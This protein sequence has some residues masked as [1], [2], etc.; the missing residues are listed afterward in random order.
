MH[1]STRGGRGV[2]SAVG[3][4]ASGQ[5]QSQRHRHVR[6]SIAVAACIGFSPRVLET[7]PPRE[8]GRH[9]ALHAPRPRGRRRFFGGSHAKRAATTLRTN[10]GIASR[11]KQIAP[12]ADSLRLIL[13]QL[14]VKSW[15]LLTNSTPSRPR[16]TRLRVKI[17]S[18]DGFAS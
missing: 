9:D 6:N 1:A 13:W 11:H 18:T 5:V 17:F 12:P 16:R 14:F 15:R 4:R 7:M 2:H 8:R 3:T 10:T